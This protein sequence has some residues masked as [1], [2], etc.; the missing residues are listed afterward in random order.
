MSQYGGVPPGQPLPP[1]MSYYYSPP[2]PHGPPGSQP[3]VQGFVQSPV[4]AGGPVRGGG[5]GHPFVRP[6]GGGVMGYGPLH[7]RYSG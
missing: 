3:P 4:A 6:G 2:M 5:A 1:G 7:T